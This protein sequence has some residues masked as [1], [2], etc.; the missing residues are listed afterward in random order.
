MEQAPDLL[1]RLVTLV[2]PRCSATRTASAQFQCLQRAGE[3]VVTWPRAYHAGFSH[4]FN[5]GEAVNFGTA[6]WVL[7]GRAAVEEY[8]RGVGKRDA[9]FS[10]D[11]LVFDAAKDVARK[12][13]RGHPAPWIAAVAA[14][15]RDELAT[16]ADEQEKGRAALCRPGRST[17]SGRGEGAANDDAAADDGEETSAARCVSPCPTSPWCDARGVGR[18]TRRPSSRLR[19]RRR[20]RR[21]NPSRGRR[22]R[23]W[24]AG[25]DDPGAGAE[26]GTGA[27]SVDAIANDPCFACVTR[28]TGADTPRPVA[29]CASARRWP[30]SGR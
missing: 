27:R 17:R 16:I 22:L 1:H 25:E 21:E 15:L 8:A 24:V 30:S 14:V 3:F 29:C 13:A 6:E 28:W 11:R 19:S 23:S 9:I 2:P 20:A 5:V 18:R 26:G 7:S 4:G 10:R 12:L